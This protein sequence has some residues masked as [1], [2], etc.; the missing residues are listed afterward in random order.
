A[1][2][3]SPP[4][5]PGPPPPRLRRGGR[6]LPPCGG[7]D[8]RRGL[9]PPA[10]GGPWGLRPPPTGDGGSAPRGEAPPLLTPLPPKHE[11]RV[12]DH[13]PVGSVYGGGSEAPPTNHNPRRDCVWRERSSLQ[14]LPTTP[15]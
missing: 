7:E 10:R 3:G 15:P 14:S 6:A 12:G 13:T 8:W 9:R 11:V 1:G 4:P 2:V 5:A